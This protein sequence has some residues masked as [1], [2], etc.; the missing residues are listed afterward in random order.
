M[1]DIERFNLY[2]LCHAMTA[3]VA[4]IEQYY[5]DSLTKK[6]FVEKSGIL[7]DMLDLQ[8]IP[9]EAED[10]IKRL[11]DIDTEASRIVEIPRLNLQEKVSVQLLFLS[12]FQGIIH[13][14]KLRLEAEQQKDSYGFALDKLEAMDPALSPMLEYWENFK[15]K[16]VQFYLEKFTGII[17]ITSKMF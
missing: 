8:L 4:A 13:E 6:F 5:Y 17:G 16:T 2:W 14:E 15:L 1:S 10:L 11:R 9:A 12:K 3:P 7:F